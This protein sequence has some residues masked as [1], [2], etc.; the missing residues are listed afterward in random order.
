MLD[1][2]ERGLQIPNSQ[3]RAYLRSIK[4]ACIGI[5]TEGSIAIGRDLARM[6]PLS[7]AWWA[8]PA[9]VMAIKRLLDQQ[10]SV[11]VQAAAAALHLPL[12]EHSAALARA[13]QCVTYLNKMLAAAK[14][15]GLLKEFNAGYRAKRIRALA[16][17][18]R[19]GNYATYYR[20]LQKL[21]FER[22]NNKDGRLDGG[23]IAKA[24][25][26]AS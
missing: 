8:P 14:A 26:T 1:E 13:Q 12:T 10:S 9:S 24:L 18:R 19:I 2:C 6:P 11:D 20:R 7:A 5:T 15:D 25:D 4:I 3:T 17:G 16:E 23:L 21:I 22:A